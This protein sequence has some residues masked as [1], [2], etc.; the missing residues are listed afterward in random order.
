M[1]FQKMRRPLDREKERERKKCVGILSP[2]FFPFLFHLST[3]HPLS[4]RVLVRIPTEERQ[5]EVIREDHEA[6]GGREG[7]RGKEK[8]G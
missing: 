8:R 5:R 1:M 2:I 6:T 4:P 7:K 3:S